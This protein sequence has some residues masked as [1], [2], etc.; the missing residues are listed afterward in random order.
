MA[1]FC[2][3]LSLWG[4]VKTNQM[5]VIGGGSLMQN[6]Q[7]VQ[8]TN[9]FIEFPL[10]D[11]ETSIP[12]RLEKQVALYPQHIAI[13]TQ[14][15]SITYEAL[16]S[17]ANQ[18]TRTVLAHSKSAAQPVGLLFEPGIP[19]IAA[20][21]G[22]LK[23]GHIWVPLD[24]TY[25]QSRLRYMLED[26]QAALLLTHN[27]IETFAQEFASPE[28]PV[29]SIDQMEPTVS[30]E[31]LKLNIPADTIAN[32]VYTSGSTAGRLALRDLRPGRPGPKEDSARTRSSRSTTGS[33]S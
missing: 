6:Q 9:S 18:I 8:P 10:E 2:S 17:L 13:K 22:V 7:P 11:I 1:S 27:Q 14:H 24:P 15:D 31:N 26:S 32:L 33:R 25:P 20:M 29:I 23:A 19:L 12:A 28:R 16:N 30:I 3:L 4:E 5:A 21:C